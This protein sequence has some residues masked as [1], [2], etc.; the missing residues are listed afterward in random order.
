MERLKFIWGRICGVRR[1]LATW[2]LFLFAAYL[3]VHVVFG[4]NGWVV[5]QK[6]KAEYRQV[7]SDVEKMKQENQ[8]LTEKIKALQ[9]DKETIEKEAREQL[10]YARPGEVIYVLPAPAPKPDTT[11]TAMKKDSKN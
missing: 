3:A 11:S 7:T 9:T 1:K 6:K 10:K 2:G 5:Y 8:R 4:A